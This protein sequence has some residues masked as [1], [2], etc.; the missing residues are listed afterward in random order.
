MDTSIKK[1]GKS[2]ETLRKKEPG[3][4]LLEVIIAIFIL[5]VGLLAV[6][7]MQIMAIGVNSYARHVSDS[8]TLAQSKLEELMSEDFGSLSSSSSAE[9]IDNFFSQTWIVGA[10]VNGTKRI[11]VTVTW[12]ER[13]VLPKS[14][15][16]TS[17]KVA[18][19]QAD[20]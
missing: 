11:T 12:N 17:L 20:F 7:N 18:S 19:S 16:L 4:T 8:T 2:P 5:T 15:S 3:F 1:S 13:G 10:T 9:A 14:T 6:A